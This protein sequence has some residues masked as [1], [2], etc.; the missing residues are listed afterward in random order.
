VSTYPKGMKSYVIDARAID[1]TSRKL[2][3]IT[4]IVP[5]WDCPKTKPI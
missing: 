5:G 2:P 3:S 4:S 1:T